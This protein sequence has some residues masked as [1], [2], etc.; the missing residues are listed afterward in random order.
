MPATTQVLGTIAALALAAG[1]TASP[2]AADVRPAAAV[3]PPALSTA[4]AV[5]TAPDDAAPAPEEWQP[6]GPAGLTGPVSEVLADAPERGPVRV[7]T[8]TADSAGRPEVS[9]TVAE[10]RGEAAEAVQDARAVPD[11]LAIAVDSKVS[12]VGGA[13]PLLA[14]GTASAAA[15]WVDDAYRGAQW[16]LNT[17][18]AESV[19][20]SATGAGQIVAVV[21]SGVD[22]AHPDLAGTV[23]SGTDL[24]VDRGTGQS[25]PNGH[26]THVAGI[27]AAKAGNGV[28]IAGLAHG[29]KILPVRV[30]DADGSGW[31][32]DVA[33]GITYA[34]DHGATVINLS[35][36]SPGSDPMVRS[37]IDYALA[38]DVVVVAAAGNSAQDCSKVSNPYPGE[39]CGNPVNYPAAFPGVVGVAATD[40]ADA[41]AAFS[42]YGSYVDVAAPGVR[43]RST[44]PSSRYLD[45]SG[46]SMA[47]PYAAA[48]VALIRAKFP[49]M[50][51]AQAT[52]RLT[53]TARDLGTAGRDPYYGAGLVQPLAALSGPSG[54]AAPVTAPAPTPATAPTPAPVSTVTGLK[55]SATTVTAGQSV[56][57][58]ATVR[59]SSGTGITGT[60]QLC[61]RRVTARAYSCANVAVRDGIAAKSLRVDAGTYVYARFAGTATAKASTSAAVR[62][63]ARPKA[64]VAGGRGKLSFQVYQ[65]RRQRVSVQ[66]YHRGAWRTVKTSAASSTASRTVS[67]LSRGT[68]RVVVAASADLLTVTSGKTAVR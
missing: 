35:L 23:L 9:V 19:W 68:Y 42:E 36:G 46:T 59:T 8:L 48:T 62:I 14:A 55:V 61:S 29:A 47:S 18:S 50:S 7:V 54:E 41:R 10:D 28:G 52:A 22:A 31:S 27:V 17:L 20:K 2:A 6:S 40:S 30:L 1:L 66:R 15:A 60:A 57:A 51:A 56:V 33:A 39:N 58:T 44:Y 32:S 64:T 53:G 11:T 67:G 3:P 25:D 63:H 24:V 49:A 37:A 45:M 16:P 38:K 4:P 5:S 43:V 65:P 12:A 13:S 26:G 34:A 21:D